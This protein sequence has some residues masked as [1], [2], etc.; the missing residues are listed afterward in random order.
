ME[1]IPAAVV[2]P[3][4][5]GTLLLGCYYGFK[6]LFDLGLIEKMPKIIAV[7]SQHCALYI[8]LLKTENILLMKLQIQEL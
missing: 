6:E 1:E 4:G 3:V 7:Q 5:N 2:I 8:K